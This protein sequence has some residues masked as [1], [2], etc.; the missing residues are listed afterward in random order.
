MTVESKSPYP[1]TGDGLA[2]RCTACGQLPGCHL[3]IV[4]ERLLA[5]DV[6]HAEVVCPPEWHGGGGLAHGGWAAAILVEV[7]GHLPIH[8][9]QT[10]LTGT[11][12]VRYVKSVPIGTPIEITAR[13]NRVE[14]RKWFVD[15]DMNL[16]SSGAILNTAKGIFIDR[17]VDHAE[18]SAAWL[19]QQAAQGRPTT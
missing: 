1:D 12:E 10:A 16:A 19:A 18:R 11:V 9:G 5:P 3:G 17:L 14:G 2:S 4:R 7:L 15:A 13:L 6:V 8:M